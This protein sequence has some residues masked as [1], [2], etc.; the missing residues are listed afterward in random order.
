MVQS[1]DVL[2]EM[3]AD[4]WLMG[5]I[6]ANHALSDLYAS[7]A[8]PLSALASITLP[9]SSPPIQERELKQLLAGALHQ[10]A[11][12]D[13]QL[14][15]GHSLQGQEL[16]IGFVVNGSPISATDGFLAKNGLK[17]GDHLLLTKPLGTGVLFA[18][19]MQLKVDGR[20]IQAAVES[21]LQ[22]NAKAAQLAVQHG[23]SACTDVTGFGLLGHLLE[24]L[25]PDQ[26]V[27]LLLD[28]IPLMAGAQKGVRDGILSTMHGANAIARRSIGQTAPHCDLERQ[29]LLFDPQTSGGLL[30]GIAADK[31]ARL[32]EALQL[33][34]YECAELIGEVTSRNSALPGPVVL[35]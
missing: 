32:C 11:Q 21:M 3:V 1:I 16:N 10:F 35:A 2:R 19:H 28:T 6:A 33:A 8:R 26:G 29:E 7:G 22:S 15:G 17:V 25:A 4:P 9:F 24:M 34:G 20:H 31:S 13:C 14:R 18:G 5:R 30:I 23:A 12:A 27:E